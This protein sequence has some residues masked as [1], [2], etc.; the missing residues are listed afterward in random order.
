MAFRDP[1]EIVARHYLRFSMKDQ[2]GTLA[3]VA[4]VLG[5]HRI[6]IDSVMQKEA[7][8]NAEFVPVIIVTGPAQERAMADALA[9][10]AGLGG[11]TDRPTVRY[12]IEDFE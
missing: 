8:T 11:L 6:G 4:A 7:P 12:R 5:D 9:A 1:G 2:P 3:R 10:I